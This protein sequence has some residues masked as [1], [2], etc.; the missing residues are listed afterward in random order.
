MVEC[1]EEDREEDGH[2]ALSRPRSKAFL[3]DN[4]RSLDIMDTSLRGIYIKILP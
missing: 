2:W 3:K 1:E 4:E